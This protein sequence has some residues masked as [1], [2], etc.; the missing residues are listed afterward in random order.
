MIKRR[1]CVLLARVAYIAALRVEDDGDFRHR[2]KDIR[3]ALAKRSPPLFALCFIKCRVQLEGAHEV[4]CRINDGAIES[5]HRLTSTSFSRRLGDLSLLAV[6][7]DTDEFPLVPL[8]L[9]KLPEITA[10]CAQ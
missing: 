1:A 9:E 3:Y 5:K 4:L 10:H 8:R 2:L 7:P 6:E